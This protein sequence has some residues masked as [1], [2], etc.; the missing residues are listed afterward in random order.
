MDV[1]LDLT[2][3]T[4]NVVRIWVFC[5][6]PAAAWAGLGGGQVGDCPASRYSATAL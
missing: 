2:G 4:S 3:S 6:R 1:G 5:A